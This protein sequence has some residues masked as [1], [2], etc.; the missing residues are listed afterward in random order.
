MVGFRVRVRGREGVRVIVRVGFRV[1]VRVRVGVRVR[2]RVRF[3]V[4]VRVGVWVYLD[5]F[6]SLQNVGGRDS[7]EIVS[8]TG[9]QGNNIIGES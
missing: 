6:N 7:P 1:R 2:V 8:R 9:K 4:R 3:R 5:T